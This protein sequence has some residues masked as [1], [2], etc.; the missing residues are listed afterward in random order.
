MS[1]SKMVK[2]RVISYEMVVKATPCG[3]RGEAMGQKQKST[4]A[5]TGRIPSNQ[6]QAMNSLVYISTPAK[7]NTNQNKNNNKEIKH[8]ERDAPWQPLKRHFLAW[9]RSLSMF[10]YICW[11]LGDVDM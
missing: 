6:G 1:D 7:S 9:W 11:N 5:N 8:V 2:V 10:F 4:T 3:G